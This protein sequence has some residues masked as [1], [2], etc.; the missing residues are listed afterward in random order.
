MLKLV[1]VFS[2]MLNVGSGLLWYAINHHPDDV[3]DDCMALS[4]KHQTSLGQCETYTKESV[5][6]MQGMKD[7]TEGCVTSLKKIAEAI[8]Y[9]AM[10]K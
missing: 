7:V 10:K 9:S 4:D 5:E 6:V 1:L 3:L 2:L 8:S